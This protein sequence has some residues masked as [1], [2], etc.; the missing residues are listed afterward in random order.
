M[1]VYKGFWLSLLVF[2]TVVNCSRITE[3]VEQKV[4]QKIDQKIDESMKKLDSSFSKEKL[5]SLGKLL[6]SASVK[7]QKKPKK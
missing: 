1:R 4:N 5:D 2:A 7:E 3:K 6:D